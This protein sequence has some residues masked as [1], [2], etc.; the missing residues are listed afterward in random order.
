MGNLET[1][2][3]TWSRSPASWTRGWGLNYADIPFQQW[4]RVYQVSV[5]CFCSPSSPFLSFALSRLAFFLFLFSLSVLLPSLSLFL[6]LLLSV[7]CWS[8]QTAMSSKYGSFIRLCT[9][10]PWSL[11][12]TGR[13]HVAQPKSATS[14]P[15]SRRMAWSTPSTPTSESTGHCQLGRSSSTHEQNP[16]RRHGFDNVRCAAKSWQK[17]RTCS[18]HL[19]YPASYTSNWNNHGEHPAGLHQPTLVHVGSLPVSFFHGLR[20]QD[21]TGDTFALRNEDRLIE[22]L[23]EYRPHWTEGQE[24]GILFP[25][26]IRHFTSH[27]QPYIMRMSCHEALPNRSMLP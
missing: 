8:S 4:K 17:W 16:W 10:C 14:Q 3:P 24:F 12:L 15:V 19:P 2:G 25:N 11:P 20:W 6:L 9:N 7:H 22:L 21:Q 26:S 18:V 1:N 5:V 13:T 27:Y 23:H